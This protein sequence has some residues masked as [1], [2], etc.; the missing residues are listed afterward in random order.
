MEKK[1]YYAI[2]VIFTTCGFSF[3]SWISRTPELRDILQATTGTMG[4]ILLGLSMGSILG[5][6]LANVFVR[7]R[8]GRF[9]IMTSAFFY[10]WR[11]H[12]A[13]NWGA[14]RGSNCGFHCLVCIWHGGWDVQCC[15]EFGRNR[16]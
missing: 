3:S 1:W 12:H 14:H 10:V 15:D 6:V 13:G 5:L 9:A 11:L 2:L 4:I 7:A 16:D 8:G